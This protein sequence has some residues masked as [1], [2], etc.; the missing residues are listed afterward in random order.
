[1]FGR[2]SFASLVRSCGAFPAAKRIMQSPL[3]VTQ[4]KGARPSRERLSL[5]GHTFCT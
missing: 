2:C 1:V 3:S 5:P 4:S